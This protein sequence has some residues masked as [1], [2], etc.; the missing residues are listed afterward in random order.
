VDRLAKPGDAV[1]AGDLLVRVHARSA[2]DA[3]TACQRLRSAFT[4]T[5][6]PPSLPPL[7]VEVL[8]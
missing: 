2:S 7:I 6:T 5:E 4:I 3:E 1:R 8:A